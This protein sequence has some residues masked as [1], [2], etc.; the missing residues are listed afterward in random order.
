MAKQRIPGR[1][2][3]QRAAKRPNVRVPRPRGGLDA[4][5]AAYA[6]LLTDP[7]NAPIVH[8][9]YGGANGGLLMR[10]RSVF[11]VNTTAGATAGYLHWTPGAIGT[12][13]SELAAAEYITTGT[14][15]TAAGI[16]NAPGKAFLVANA[17]SYRPVAAC[18]QVYWSGSETARQGFVLLDNTLGGFIDLGG[19]YSTD[20]LS[21]SLSQFARTPGSMLELIWKPAMADETW[22][23][24]SAV[25]AAVDKD[26]RGAVS[27][28]W[29]GLPAAVGLSIV[30]TAVYEWEPNPV[31][32]LASATESRSVTKNSVRDVMDSIQRTGYS[33]I[34]GVAGELVHGALAGGVAYAQRTNRMQIG[35]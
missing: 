11:S 4:A 23:D 27:I 13:N 6:R 17:T 21:R 34:R 18:M 35:M 24:P 22:I 25:T 26:R 28:S 1:K 32:G 12:T 31:S 29:G 9:A 33:F 15:G 14:S 7:C 30:C 2:K 20:L 5:G 8:P 16:A 10:S 3:A 19:A